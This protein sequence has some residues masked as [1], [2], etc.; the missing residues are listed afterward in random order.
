MAELDWTNPKP[1]DLRYLKEIY[2]GLL[3]RM[4]AT[5]YYTGD[6]S[7]WSAYK[8]S[9]YTLPFSKYERNQ[10]NALL[11]ADMVEGSP[12]L[13]SS[14]ANI[15]L[16]YLTLGTGLTGYYDIDKNNPPE[17]RWFQQISINTYGNFYYWNVS[18]IGTNIDWSQVAGY[19]NIYIGNTISS[20]QTS[21]AQT[22]AKRA[23]WTCNA[24]NF[25]L[26]LDSDA[27][28]DIWISMYRALAS[29]GYLQAA[30]GGIQ[31]DNNGNPYQLGP[32]WSGSCRSISASWLHAKES[33]WPLDVGVHS[34]DDYAYFQ[35]CAEAW[36]YAV[37]VRNIGND[38]NDPSNYFAKANYWGYGGAGSDG[39]SSDIPSQ[40]RADT[41]DHQ[42]YTFQEPTGF[43]DQGNVTGWTT[44]SYDNGTF[45]AGSGQSYQVDVAAAF[46]YTADPNALVDVPAPGSL[47]YL[48]PP[49]YQWDSTDSSCNPIRVSQ[50]PNPPSG[51][52]DAWGDWAGI[53]SADHFSVITALD[54]IGFNETK[55]GRIG[56]T[57]DF[58]GFPGDVSPPMPASGSVTRTKQWQA[59]WSGSFYVLP[60]FQYCAQPSEN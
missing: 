57:D 17:A 7:A 12:A 8:P 39:G 25:P 55:T 1:S 50:F 23:K 27:T 37:Q 41:I 29:P 48:L 3:E 19:E 45:Y 9:S 30:S 49:S 34:M 11:C 31:Y 59:V 47:I 28:K 36:A 16:K 21:T 60:Q 4:Y 32:S 58:S 42:Y 38:E 26:S 35:S 18:T 2:L 53:P 13:I 22:V 10:L 40:S 51:A 56:N 43:D 20:V 6:I 24:I 14:C 5:A 44:Y 15:L 46:P 33:C 54:G 52:I